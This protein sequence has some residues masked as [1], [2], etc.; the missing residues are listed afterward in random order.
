MGPSQAQVY[1]NDQLRVTKDLT[2]PQTQ[3]N[4]YVEGV[5][6][7]E[8]GPIQCLTRFPAP[9]PTRTRVPDSSPTPELTSSEPTPQPSTDPLSVPSPTPE[10]TSKP[11][12]QSSTDPASGP[13]MAIIAV[14]V[15]CLS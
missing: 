13:F 7:E 4:C 14:I 8:D 3:L 6:F 9:E 10:L 1:C 12:P 15:W 5:P 11:T 2:S